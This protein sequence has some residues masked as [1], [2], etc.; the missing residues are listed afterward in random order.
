M[1][2]ICDKC[3]C[4]VE[5]ANDIYGMYYTRDQTDVPD[6]PN[7]VQKLFCRECAADRYDNDQ[8]K[9]QQANQI[10][11]EHLRQSGRLA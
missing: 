3:N 11:I 10:A 1:S 9:L 7:K 8:F 2:L 4:G 6:A 5:Y